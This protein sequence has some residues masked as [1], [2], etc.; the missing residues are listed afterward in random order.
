MKIEKVYKRSFQ[1]IYE[2][3][4]WSVEGPFDLFMKYLTNTN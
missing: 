4:K 3:R 1:L 2:N